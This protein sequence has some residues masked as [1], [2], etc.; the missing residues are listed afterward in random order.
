[1][2]RRLLVS[3]IA[4][5]MLFALS[6]AGTAAA[7]EAGGIFRRVSSAIESADRAQLGDLFPADRKIA[8]S[9]H[10]IAD[11]EGFAGAGPLAEAF[12]RYLST[13]TEIR[14]EREP[15]ARHDG[16]ETTRVRGV[17]TSRD[18]AGKSQRIVLTFV[19]EGAGQGLK[20]VEVRETG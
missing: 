13:R 3:L 16:P 5:L 17:L 8:V 11:L 18:R 1:M 4:P 19:F 7:P 6:R 10:Q 14:F 15:G 2:T 9:L 12:H 20:A